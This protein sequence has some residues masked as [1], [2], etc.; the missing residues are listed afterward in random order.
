MPTDLRENLAQLIAGLKPNSPAARRAIYDKARDGLKAEIRAAAPFLPVQTALEKTRELEDA[1]KAVEAEASLHD[2]PTPPPLRRPAPPP[3]PPPAD[4]APASPPSGASPPV[5][6]S[7]LI[8]PPVPEASPVA[9]LRAP[10]LAPTGLAIDY[11]VR[12]TVEPQRTEAFRFDLEQ[13]VPQPSEAAPAETE[14][15]AMESEAPERLEHLEP[16]VRERAAPRRGLPIYLAVAGA[17]VMVAVIAMAFIGSL[18]GD[19]GF[20]STKTKTS[21]PP[22]PRSGTVG[23]APL[24]SPASELIK[25]AGF[26]AAAEDAIRQGNLLL[27][28][29]DH[30]GAIA[31]FDDAIRLERSQAAP[32]GGRAYA[33]WKTGNIPAAIRDYGEAIRLDP[34][35]MEHRLN[36]AAAYNRTGEYQLA[37]ADLDHVVAAQPANVDALNSRCWARAL[38]QHLQEALADCDEAVRLRSNDPNVLDSRGFVYLRLGRLDRAIAD[39]S[40]ALKLEPRLAGALYG[41]GLARI[42]RGDRAGGNEDVAAARAIDPEIQAT[43]ARYGVR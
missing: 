42:G 38:L 29:G 20:F 22:P 19:L 24:R 30:D 4:V 6:V 11:E 2:P 32:Y 21:A 43:F 7:E 23:P 18:F 16:S 37:V 10:L 13:V 41:R 25:G 31:A 8:T 27:A 35:N 1:I 3:P 28:R 5:P 17:A 12:P 26:S 34:S 39:Y 15:E 9:A 14:I 33:Y 40:E 36:R